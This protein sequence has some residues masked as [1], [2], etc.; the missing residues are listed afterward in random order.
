MSGRLQ[1]EVLMIVPGTTQWARLVDDMPVL[2][3]LCALAINAS[4][5]AARRAEEDDVD[6]GTRD[7]LRRTI[8]VLFT[9]QRRHLLLR[10]KALH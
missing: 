4:K 2:F 3:S 5:D 1:S 9:L 6:R 8:A 10:L 7:E